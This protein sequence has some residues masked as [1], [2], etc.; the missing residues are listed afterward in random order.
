[1]YNIGL[2]SYTAGGN[3]NT[4]VPLERVSR[5]LKKLNM[6]LL[7]FNH[8]TTPRYLSK[9]NESICW[10]EGLY[11]NIYSSLICN[12]KTLETNKWKQVNCDI[13][14]QWNDIQHQNRMNYWYPQHMGESQN[15]HVEWKKQK[16]H[17]PHRPTYI[18]C[19]K[20][21]LT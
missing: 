4:K 9:R 5:V 18:D 12:S 14:K 6:H 13:S 16:G 1:M 19:R 11:K 20:C 17:I 15:S 7:R 8:S 3:I 2:L 21:R 10:F